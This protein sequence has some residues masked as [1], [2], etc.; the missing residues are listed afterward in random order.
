MGFVAGGTGITPFYPLIKNALENGDDVK[1]NLLYW[2]KTENDIIFKTE[3]DDLQKQFSDRFQL[4]HCISN[5]IKNHDDFDIE[6]IGHIDAELI[7]K[8]MPEPSKNFINFAY[9]VKIIS[10]DIGTVVMNMGPKGMNEQFGKIIVENT[11]YDPKTMVVSKAVDK[12][13]SQIN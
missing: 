1:I 13:L 8:T 12:L 3:L 11:Q 4:S 6:K 5:P 2:N 10:I 9:F 7:K